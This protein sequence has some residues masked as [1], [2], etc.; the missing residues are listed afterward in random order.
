MATLMIDWDQPRCP[1]L[2]GNYART[3]PMRRRRRKSLPD[4]RADSIHSLVGPSMNTNG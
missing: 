1:T 2:E 4:L 3:R